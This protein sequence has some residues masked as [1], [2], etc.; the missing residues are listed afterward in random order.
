MN[1]SHLFLAMALASASGALFAQT[2]GTTDGG[3]SMTATQTAPS[4]TRPARGARFAALQQ[5][6]DADFKAY[7]PGMTP[8]DGKLGPC[9]RANVAK[10]SPT[11]RSA[12][13]AMRGARAGA[14]Q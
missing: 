14:P 6:C 3:N 8:G 5:S 9:I 13:Q 11:C 7:C 2:T 10:L 4:D 1:K 12:L